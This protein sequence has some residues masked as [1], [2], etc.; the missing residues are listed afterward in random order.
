MFGS[1]YGSFIT[2]EESGLNWSL[3]VYSKTAQG[4]IS[5][6]ARVEAFLS[7]PPVKW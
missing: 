1:F 3:F 4:S 5:T 2:W 6:Y 7:Y